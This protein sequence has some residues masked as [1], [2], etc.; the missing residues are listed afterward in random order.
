LADPFSKKYIPVTAAC[1]LS[2]H[3]NVTLKSFP[4]YVTPLNIYTLEQKRQSSLNY[5]MPRPLLFA[6]RC[7]YIDILYSYVSLF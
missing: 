2:C 4:N 7:V 1:I 3:L 5:H 6:G